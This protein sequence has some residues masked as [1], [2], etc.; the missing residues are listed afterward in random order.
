M[1]STPATEHH[2][3][4]PRARLTSS[5]INQLSIGPAFREVAAALLRKQ[6][7][8]RYPSLNIDP[9]IVMVGT[10]SW[11]IINGEVVAQPTHYQALTDILARQAVL[12][13][14]ALFVEGIHFL[15]QLPI[16]E[17]A[18]HL[19]ARIE[20]IGLIINVLA[21][22]MIRGYQEQQLAFWS[23]TVG[24]SGPHWHELAGVLRKLWSADK[25]P[26]WTDEDCL[27][28]RQV[29]QSPDLEDRK[30]NDPYSTHA[31]VLDVDQ[32]DDQGTATH[33][34]EHL[35]S[36]VIGQ[37]D[38]HDVILA[39]SMLLGFRK[40][41]S[42]EALGEDLP[43][44]LDTAI[45]HKTIQWRLVEPDG[46]FFD[47]LACTLVTIQIE[48][49]GAIDFSD[50]RGE[51]ASPL[52]M[53]GPPGATPYGKR[54]D[55]D[56]DW[57]QQALPDWLANA[58]ISDMNSYSRYL[59]NLSALH[60]FYQGKTYNEGIAPIEQYALDR[61]RAE[62]LKDH[63][64]ATD[65]SLGTLQ[66]KV[67]SPV[68]W[69][70]FPVPGQ[71]DT[72]LYSLTQ[73]ALQNL[74]NVPLG[75]KT[76]RQKAPY[77]LPDWLTVDY[78][79][80]LIDRIDIG[81]TYPQLIKRTLLGDTAETDRRR[82]L[83]GHYLAV[84]LPLLALQGKI[85]QESGLDE[86]GYRFVAAVMQ[87]EETDRQVDGQAIVMRPL[88]F[89]P[90]YR[91]LDS[92]PD[93]VATMFVIGPQDIT[94]GPCVLYRPLLDMPLSQY[95]SPANLV[96]AI[97]QTPS[98]RESVLAW[99]PDAARS[100]YS[101]Y[102]FPAKIPSP[103]AIAEVVTNPIKLVTL[104]GPLNLGGDAISGDLFASLYD[105][106]AR[107]LIELADRQSVSNA[108]AR[109]A[110]LKRAGWAIFNGVLPFLGRAVGT[111]A[112]VWQ[113]MDQVQA[114]VDATEHHDASARR[115]A[116]S[117]LLLN[118]G[119]AIAMHAAARTAPRRALE[120]APSREQPAP[121][122]TVPKPAPPLVKQ[123]PTLSTANLPNDHL[124]PLHT[125][126][127]LTLAPKRLGA[128]LDSFQVDKPDALNKPISDAG[129]YRHLYQSG[130]KYYAPVGKRWFEV[131]V[132]D[133]DRA[134]IVDPKNPERTGPPLM[135][136]K[137]GQ[138][139]VDPR[140]RLRGGGPTF[141]VQKAKTL[142]Q[143]RAEQLK[144]QLSE[145]EKDKQ[146]LQTEL[147]QAR[148][149]MDAGPET[150]SPSVAETSREAYFSTL[151]S[152][153]TRYESAL[154]KLKQLA[155]H[156]YTPDYLPKALGYLKAQTELTL[157]GIKES[158]TRFQPKMNDV[159]VRIVR[160]A[161]T[162]SE[163]YINEARQMRELIPQMLEHLAYMQT[164]LEEMYQ[165]GTDGA[166]LSRD[167]RHALP[168][169]TEMDLKS[170]QVT[171]A[172]NLCLPA[173]TT[174]AKPEAW[175]AIDKI[176]D[177]ADLA[178]MGLRDTLFERSESRLDERIDLLS[179]LTEQFQM[180]DERLEDFAVTFS[181]HALEPNVQALRDQ[182]TEFQ[183][184]TTHNLALL[185]GERDSLRS[186]TKPLPAPPLAQKKFIRTRYDGLLIGEPRLDRARQE[187]KFV[188]IRSP[189]TEK[190]YATYHE[191]DGVWVRHWETAPIT[192]VV[193]LL[194]ATRE[195]QALLDQLPGFLE[196]AERHA[197]KAQRT[198]SGIEY[199]YHQHAHQ[200]ENSRSAISRGLTQ[201]N[202]AEIDIRAA[203]TVRQALQVAV[204]NLYEQSE[205]HMSTV[206][207]DASPTVTGVEWLVR[208]TAITIKQTRFREPIGP[209]P[210][211]LDEYAIRDRKT[212]QV[213]WYAHFEYSQSWSSAERYLSG[214]LKTV[215]E[216][217]SGRDAGSRESGN[218][219]DRIAYLRSEIS[220]RPA[221]QLFFQA[222]TKQGE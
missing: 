159:L 81:N 139:F 56:M 185:S 82:V 15:T 155:V 133:N 154:Q 127:A 209:K 174:T 111:A 90:S 83:Y 9:D 124:S 48:A 199:L 122:P 162:P 163:R 99:L 198:P 98:L 34:S 110:T 58:S 88:A 106:N 95:P 169:Y 147:R 63:P 181:E 138:W 151:K 29:F 119:M 208:H 52:S 8:R 103:W 187:T 80:K 206:I 136:N 141:L 205:G 175:G 22:V 100:D 180:L 214:R 102:V 92:T 26:G 140:L 43:L 40:Y 182:L 60:T 5:L 1:P 204:K 216:Q 210:I 20:D 89:V 137:Q 215:R 116:L 219:A 203:K 64:E 178:I 21:P 77:T 167:T 53:A 142:A 23:Q 51:D 32:V 36:V 109:W 170:L 125:S 113:I 184:K 2:R 177:S 172:R 39:H 202:L 96:Y 67:Q 222:S 27:M 76:L 71:F 149:D 46:D 105:A 38:K 220:L 120:T 161:E 131:Q 121:P 79:E 75:I 213:L 130:Q 68:V 189:L 3:R 31:Y 157:A 12:A 19:A 173:S 188:D 153:C 16:T 91:V 69:G 108:E 87:P 197:T 61:F 143:Q 10:P 65:L 211:Y 128:V 193:D 70:L 123:L 134:I 221:T 55:E 14:P 4:P 218:D 24:E 195:G 97:Q 200:L 191:K 196:Q 73:L 35:V 7:Q 179:S 152:Q 49:I 45:T 145:F 37:Q 164:R 84:Q 25:V 114:L 186:R 11:K 183:R 132:N 101:N 146:T 54:P 86:R 78:V 150:G 30:A 62:M 13:V 41:A 129:P 94:A 6:L 144:K 217:L 57:L 93:V 171:I 44:L 192:P 190:I 158:Q 118:L 201:K 166:E 115:V 17:P 168:S 42:L 165:L 212:L 28:A 160:Q 156:A 18:V 135:H 207:R 74:I 107:A 112:W 176:V 72:T 50:L 85:R 117:D 33:L 126:G 104:S 59:K 194:R 66:L 148:E 47:Y